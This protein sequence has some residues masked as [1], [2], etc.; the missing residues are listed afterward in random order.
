MNKQ[1]SRAYHIFPK[2]LQIKKVK[3][4]QIGN[5]VIILFIIDAHSL[6]AQRE[7]HLILFLEHLQLP[8]Q[9]T[10]HP[11]RMIRAHPEPTSGTSLQ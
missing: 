5:S 4:F 9:T 2:T 11:Q 7:V 1:R 10:L 8:L 3:L 6:K